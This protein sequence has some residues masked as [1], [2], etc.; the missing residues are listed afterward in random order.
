MVTAKPQ[1]LQGSYF[2]FLLEAP[3]QPLLWSCFYPWASQ[4]MSELFAL[5]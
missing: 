4:I 5:C 1:P 3:L 2:L